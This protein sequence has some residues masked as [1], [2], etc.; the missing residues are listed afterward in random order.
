MNLKLT[1][2]LFSAV[3]VFGQS[4]AIAGIQISS[5]RIIYPEGADEVQE[6]V[7]NTGESNQLVQ[8]WVDNIDKNDQRKP[9]FIVTPPLFKLP[10]GQSNI[11]HFISIDKTASLATD[12]EQIFWANIKSIEATPKALSQQSK[13]QLAARTR[14]KLIWRPKGLDKNSA[15]EAYKQLLFSISGS[16]LTVEN[17]TAYYV[18]LQKF[19]VDGKDIHAPK[20]T[21]A[22]VSMMISPFSKM[23]YTIPHSSAKTIRWNAIDDY[24]NGT[25]VQEKT[26]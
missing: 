19:T 6:T 23:V 18:S 17:P 21:I 15:A 13:L 22:A 14:I 20:N 5:T 12:R 2:I 7:K 11:L 9:P 16:R 10:G 1:G 4:I 3:L 25:P 24:G 8:A 26:F